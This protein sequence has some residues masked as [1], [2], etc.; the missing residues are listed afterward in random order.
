[1]QELEPQFAPL[2]AATVSTAEAER[3]GE[4][5][6]ELRRQLQTRRVASG[7]EGLEPARSRWR[8]HNQPFFVLV[9]IEDVLIRRVLE[10]LLPALVVEVW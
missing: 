3:L 2:E 4:F 7:R 5:A 6:E 9:V 10:Y 8:Q 1:M